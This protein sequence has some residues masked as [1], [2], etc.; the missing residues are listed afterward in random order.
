MRVFLDKMT[1]SSGVLSS[2]CREGMPETQLSL[3][4]SKLEDAYDLGELDKRACMPHMLV[5]IIN[6]KRHLG[7]KARLRHWGSAMCFTACAFVILGLG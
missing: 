4:I 7:V 6:D 1:M 3:N 2:P 5:V